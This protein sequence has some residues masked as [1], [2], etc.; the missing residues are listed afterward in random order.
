M[1]G[2]AVVSRAGLAGLFKTADF[3]NN[4]VNLVPKAGVLERCSW[5]GTVLEQS[6][7]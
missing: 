3:E 4:S 1:K 6:H 7:F 2:P 5:S